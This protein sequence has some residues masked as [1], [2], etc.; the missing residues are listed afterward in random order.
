MDT[1]N[2]SINDIIFEFLIDYLN[3][4]KA[5]LFEGKISKVLLNNYIEILEYCL[6]N[7]LL[8]EYF[9]LSIID[10]IKLKKFEIS[11]SLKELNRKEL[12]KY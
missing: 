4:I 1:K 3:Y 12:E 5:Y 10:Q 7:D 9:L 6:G 2:D 11:E 8:N